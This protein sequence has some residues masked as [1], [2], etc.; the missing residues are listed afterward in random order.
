MFCIAHHYHSANAKEF[1]TWIPAIVVEWGE[2]QGRRASDDSMSPP[3]KT[4]TSTMISTFTTSTTSTTF[5]D[6]AE[7][8]SA[9][10][11]E[12]EPSGG[13]TAPTTTTTTMKAP[14]LASERLSEGNRTTTTTMTITTTTYSMHKTITRTTDSIETT[15]SSHEA[16]RHSGTIFLHVDDLEWFLSGDEQVILSLSEGLAAAYGVN[17]SDVMVHNVTAG[18]A[19]TRRLELR[20]AVGAAARRRLGSGAVRVDYELL[21]HSLGDTPPLDDVDESS[22]QELMKDIFRAQGVI[23]K[24]LCAALSSPSAAG[25]ETE[26]ACDDYDPTLYEAPPALVTSAPG[27]DN[28]SQNAYPIACA[29]ACK[30]AANISG[31]MFVG[32]VDDAIYPSGCYI[33]IGIN[34]AFFNGKPNGIGSVSRQVVCSFQPVWSQ[35]PTQ[36]PTPAPAPAYV[37]G[38]TDGSCPSGTQRVPGDECQVLG[39][40]VFPGKEAGAWAREACHMYYTPGEGCF[41]NG[42]DMYSTASGCTQA[43]GRSDHFAVCRQSEADDDSWLGKVSGFVKEQKFNILFAILCGFL[44]MLVLSILVHCASRWCHSPQVVKAFGVLSVDHPPGADGRPFPD[45]KYFNFDLAAASEVLG[46]AVVDGERLVITNLRTGETRNAMFL[47]ACAG[48][49]GD[50]QGRWEPLSYAAGGQ[51]H[52]GDRI[53]FQAGDE[54]HDRAYVA[55]VEGGDA[56]GNHEQ[57]EG[58]EA[59]EAEIP[60]EEAPSEVAFVCV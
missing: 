47:T 5:T 3:T 25:N 57:H 54:G 38:G 19:P 11:H 16:L 43:A 49:D 2:G 8:T 15:T 58:Q 41:H 30:Q 1:G 44:L 14:T 18:D 45:G 60:S 39:G 21:L 28:C 13:P 50:G 48:R 42:Q 20:G 46:R 31:V 40:S 6:I 34:G 23:V 32:T 7:S 51:W 59:A 17:I 26:N 37:S 36:A 33:H 24:V 53:T 9:Q 52:V 27:D 10:A 29:E 35:C 12:A 4:A 22:L 55:D 56:H